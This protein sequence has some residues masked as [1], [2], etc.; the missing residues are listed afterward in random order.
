VLILLFNQLSL[1]SPLANGLAIPLVSLAVVP[2]AI[3]GAILP[4]DF[5]LQLAASLWQWC[6]HALFWLRQWP[7]AVCYLPTPTLWLWWLAMA[8]MLVWLL[9]R[10]WPLRWAALLLCLPLLLPK[11]P[12]LQTG[13]MR[14]T[15][16]DVGQGLSVLVQ[17]AHHSM[18]YDAGPAYNAQTD[19]GQRIVLPYLRHLGL[20]RLHMAVISHDDNDHSGGMA[21]VLAGVPAAQLLS[22][23]T[24][25]ADFFRQLRAL[26][27]APLLPHQSCHHGQ[28]W[29]WD[30]VTFRV[31]SPAKAPLAA[32]K[33]NDK[34]CV[35][36]V[37]SAHGSLLLTGDIEQEAERWLLETV[38]DQLPTSVMTMPHHGSKTSS[39]PAF[40]NATQAA[41]VIATAGYLNRFGH[42]KAEVIARYQAH[43][44]QILRSD[45]DGAVIIDF[46]SGHQ[47][48]VRR[49]RQVEPRYWERSLWE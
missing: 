43:G 29:H 28:Q 42:P 4:L 10:G 3:A 8:G 48:L 11:P 45:R 36:K 32:L 20:R 27:N 22:S 14:V 18:L 35:I 37:I 33:D 13:Q 38:A 23:L 2:L 6:A 25:E 7:G 30:G 40:V 19:A 9:P 44:A 1:I 17:T 5:L 21:S 41:V 49:W 34:S 26:A 15:V 16:L 46:L 47:P 39:T 24:P 12:L 31:L